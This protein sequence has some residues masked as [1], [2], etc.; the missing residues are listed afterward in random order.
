MNYVVLLV[1]CNHK[2]HPII[3]LDACLRDIVHIPDTSYLC[4]G[5]KNFKRKP[6]PI[7]YINTLQLCH[8]KMQNI[9]SNFKNGLAFKDK[10]I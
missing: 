7:Y 8:I 5:I 6:N 9:C 10:I 2:N 3:R 4:E 1:L